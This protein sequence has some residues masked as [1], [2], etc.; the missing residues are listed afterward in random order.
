MTTYR[1][2]E[3]VACLGCRW[4]AKVVDRETTFPEEDDDPLHKGPRV[5]ETVAYYCSN[6]NVAAGHG[7]N[8]AFIAE[9]I[10][11]AYREEG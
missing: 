5:I 10:E 6:G 8:V 11:C 7:R 4:G 1:R 3:K 9:R 2:G